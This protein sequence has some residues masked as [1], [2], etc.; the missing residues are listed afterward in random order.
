MAG[1]EHTITNINIMKLEELSKEEQIAFNGGGLTNFMYDVVYGIS[2]A[3]HASYDIAISL[4]N[5]P[6]HGNANVYK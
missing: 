2:Y 1:M 6:N 5:N 4:R 3:A